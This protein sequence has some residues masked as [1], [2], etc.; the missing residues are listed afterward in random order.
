MCCPPCALPYRPRARFALAILSLHLLVGAYP[1]AATTYFVRSSGDDSQDGLTPETARAT[2]ATTAMLLADPGDRLVV[3]PGEYYESNIRPVA[4]GTRDLPIV[5]HGDASGEF[6]GDPAGNVL[7]RPSN[8][9]DERAGI[10]LFGRHDY[11]IEGFT[12]EGA[13]DAGIQVRPFGRDS[14][15]ITI[16]NNEIRGSLQRGIEVEVAG[17]TSIAGNTVTGTQGGAGIRVAGGI[18]FAARP[19]IVD[20]RLEGNFGGIATRFVTGG[21]IVENLFNDNRRGIEL[22]AARGMEVSGNTITGTPTGGEAVLVDGALDGDASGDLS[23]VDNDIDITTGVVDITVRGD[24]DFRNNRLREIRSGS[25]G[26]R[27]RVEGDSL[28]A[29]VDNEL[30]NLSIQS[31][32][33]ADLAF[34]SNRA[35]AVIATGMGAIR[36]VANNATSLTLRGVGSLELTANTA[37]SVEADGSEVDVTDNDCARALRIGGRRGEVSTNAAQSLEVTVIAVDA[38]DSGP[39]SM[40]VSD[41]RIVGPGAFSAAPELSTTFELFR[42]TFGDLVAIQASDRILVEDTEATGLQLALTGDAGSATVR[43]CTFAGSRTDGIEVDHAFDVKIE[44][45]SVHAARGIGVFLDEGTNA[46]LVGNDIRDSGE[47]GIRVSARIAV[48]GDCNRNGDVTVD[49]LVAAVA[50]ALGESEDVTCAAIDLDDSGSVTVDEISV[51]I[52]VALGVL[53]PETP[54]SPL[55]NVRVADNTVEAAGG[56]GVR[57]RAAGTVAAG[58][59]RVLESGGVGI[60]VQSDSLESAIE[61]TDNIVGGSD[62]EG[63][64]VAGSRAMLVAG[65]RAFSNGTEGI[66]VRDCPGAA[67]VNNLSYANG[68]HGIGFGRGATI[69]SPGGLMMNNTLYA[70]GRFG[71]TLGTVGAS[72]PNTTVLNNILSGNGRGGAAAEEGSFPGLH[73]AF[74]LNN[75]GYSEGVVASVTDFTADPRWV[76]PA[77]ADEV[78]GGAGWEDDDFHLQSEPIPSA[79]IDAGSDTAAAL[80]IGGSAISGASE[81]TGMVDLGFHY[82]AE[83]DPTPPL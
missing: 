53:P 77:G 33:A 58:S 24:L 23:F 48:R 4:D 54:G 56:A 69:P 80:Q 39:A 75:D 10:T 12:I 78:L 66:V 44:N 1:A 64:V 62:D 52:G 82:P 70:N 21:R 26:F 9:G 61:V 38:N 20:N 74:N 14:T 37:E 68:G 7:I 11:I 19:T 72:A 6:T 32:S 60:F 2:I 29:L 5:L 35:G 16:R 27:V 28:V 63:V 41:N 81:D 59:N 76:S 13:A 34:D 67:V 55:P 71:F 73:I 42:N 22:E 83:A 45:T 17:D 43:D 31:A 47:D 15:R 65:N 25:S 8:F 49:E 50:I 57:I 79:A 36:A 40:L 46:F 3:G 30:G 51:A 18:S